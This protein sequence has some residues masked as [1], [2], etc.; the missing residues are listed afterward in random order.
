MKLTAGQAAKATGKS[1]ATITRAIN[2][3]TLSADKLEG[4]GYLIE[5]S[6]LYRVFPPVTRNSAAQE[7][8]A[9]RETPTATGVLQAEL[10]AL[11]EKLATESAERMREREAAAD[12]IADLR[13]RL[14]TEGEERRKLTAILT[15]QRA[16]PMTN[17]APPSPP[18]AETAPA[19]PQ[20]P[21]RGDIWA[22]LLGR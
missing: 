21:R 3:R 19:S 5:P 10:E 20:E 15:D 8:L 2:K 4:G 12:Q 14:D 17:D 13:R 22:R 1:T 7:G 11:R 16:R 6:E 18:L 9:G